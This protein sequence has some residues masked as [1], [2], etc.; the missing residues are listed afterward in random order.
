MKKNTQSKQAKSY[1]RFISFE[2]G[3]TVISFIGA[4]FGAQYLYPIAPGL[5]QAVASLVPGN[6]GIVSGFA[7]AYAAVAAL[8]WIVSNSL[9]FLTGLRRL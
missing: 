1:P 2:L 8:I 5:W 7:A 4:L 3:L 9:L 6:F